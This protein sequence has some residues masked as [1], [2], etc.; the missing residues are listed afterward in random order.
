MLLQT[1]SYSVWGTANELQITNQ[2]KNEKRVN[3][4]VGGKKITIDEIYKVTT[5]NAFIT[6]DMNALL[7]VDKYAITLSNQRKFQGSSLT[8]STSELFLPL[9][10]SKSAILYTI[11]SL[12]QAKSGVRSSVIQAIT[13]LLNY[14]TVPKFTSVESAQSELVSTLIG[15]YS[16]CYSTRGCINASQALQQAGVSPV[17]LLEHEAQ[18]LLNGGYTYP[19]FAAYIVLGAAKT[20]KS[21]DVLSAY[22]CESVGC[23]TSAFD[24]E[25][26]DTLRPHRGQMT[27]ASN[28]R[29]MLESSGN[30]NSSNSKQCC[31]SFLQIPQINGPATDLIVQALK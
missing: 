29:L 2:K 11:T 16:Y 6:L 24:A 14:G 28:I 21:I 23:S 1:K 4:V 31:A 25:N 8:S 17:E 5:Q 27:S 10:F 12:M 30:V 15:Q 3:I 18:T 19:G 20:F 26:F 13:D 9:E 7:E 22:S